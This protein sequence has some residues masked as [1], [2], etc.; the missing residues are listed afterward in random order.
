[1]KI[2]KVL[3]QHFKCKAVTWQT[4]YGELVC[5][6]KVYFTSVQPLDSFENYLFQACQLFSLTLSDFNFSYLKQHSFFGCTNSHLFCFTVKVTPCKVWQTKVAGM[7][8]IWET[9]FRLCR[10][11]AHQVKTLYTLGHRTV[12]MNLYGCNYIL[13][14]QSFQRRFTGPCQTPIIAKTAFHFI[15]IAQCQVQFSPLVK[16]QQ[17]P[18]R[19]CADNSSGGW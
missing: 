19:T 18:N 16:R 1:M 5:T 15:I 4:L 9:T 2:R 11:I 10:F 12:F 14:L 6:N 17:L 7:S 8:L 3:Q 13:F